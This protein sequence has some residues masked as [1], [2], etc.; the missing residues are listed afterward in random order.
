MLPTYVGTVKQ[1][2]R[3]ESVEEVPSGAFLKIN[4][5]VHLRDAAV[6]PNLPQTDA[7]GGPGCSGDGDK[8]ASASGKTKKKKKKGGPPVRSCVR[9]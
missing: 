7:D 6:A 8:I 4:T 1:S 9:C 2:E 5:C 3:R